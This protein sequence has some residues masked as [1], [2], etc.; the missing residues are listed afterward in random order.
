MLNKLEIKQFTVFRQASFD[1]CPGLNVI[2]GNNGTGKT[3]VLKLGYLFSR[4]WMDLTRKGMRLNRKR[5]E[6]YIEERLAGL[7]RIQEPADLIRHGHKN[8]ATIGAEVGGHIPTL[9]ITMPGEPLSPS[10]GLPE[11]MIWEMLLRRTK[12][13]SGRIEGNMIPEDAAV[14]SFVIP[15]IFIP[16]KEIIS[17]F[18]G[19][20]GLF[21][22]YRQFPLDETY[23]DLA[24]ALATLEPTAPSPLLPE[25]EQRIV[26]ML[27]GELR[28][29]DNDFLFEQKDGKTLDSHLMAEGHRKLAMLLYLVRY[30]II[31][32]GST[33]FWD[34]PEAN[35]NPEAI[36]LLAEALYTLADQGVQVVMATHSLFL[37]REFEVLSRGKNHPAPVRY[38]ALGM[39]GKGVNVSA[40]DDTLKIDPIV[41]LN[42]DL[43]QSD[44]FMEAME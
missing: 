31:E 4:A 7:F 26:T 3:H 35:L 23:K 30:K 22:A 9:K 27:G 20:I 18:K 43:A 41:L 17:M 12:E 15:S 40:G 21:E 34:E 16:S 1:F 32:T 28:L 11:I 14:N 39:S 19:L 6:S 38:F 44:R 13:S 10:R 33:V 42:E 36:R 2:I 25:L 5:A 8:G 29:V 24:V 37:L